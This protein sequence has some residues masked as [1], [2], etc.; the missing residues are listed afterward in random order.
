MAQP[1]IEPGDAEVLSKLPMDVIYSPIRMA[2][3]WA[4]A[5]ADAKESTILFSRGLVRRPVLILKNEQGVYDRV[6]IYK[7]KKSAE[8]IVVIHEDEYVS[9]FLDEAYKKDE[10]IMANR[11]ARLLEIAPDGTKVRL[12]GS[13]AMD[14]SNDTLWHPKSLLADVV[15]NVLVQALLD[16]VCASIAILIS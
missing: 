2:E 12:W 3:G 11:N 5:P 16:V 15:E 9:D 7:N 1:Q 14:F 13:A 6:A 10:K 8:P 4:D